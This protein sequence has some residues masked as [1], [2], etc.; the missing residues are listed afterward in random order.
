MDLVFGFFKNACHM[1]RANGE[2]HVNHKTTPPFDDWNIEKLAKQSFLTM[3]DC[4]DFNKEDYPGYDNKRGDSYRCDDPFPLGK[5]STFKFICNPRSMKK[6]LRGNHI[7]ISRQQTILPFHEEIQSIAQFPPPVDLNYLP[8]TSLLPKMN[9]FNCYPQT[10]HFPKLN[11]PIR[12]E[13]DLRNGY[14]TISREINNV[15]EIHGSVPCSADGYRY[16]QTNHFPKLNEPIRSEFDLRNGYNMI[17][18]E[19][20]NVTEI[21]G[22]V[23]CS[24]DGYRYARDMTQDTRR[25]VPPMESLQSLQPRPT[26][27][28]CRYSLTEP[29]RRT[30][31]MAPPMSLRARNGDHQYKAF[32]GSSSYMQ[33][34]LY[35]NAQ[36]PSY[37]QEEPYRN[38]PMPSHSFDIARYDLERYNAEVPR[39]VFNR[40]IYAMQ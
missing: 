24:A 29:L 18:R 7:E 6:H 2:I 4:I 23:A 12:S 14:N 15:T 10:N 19:I 16:P 34:E 26:P 5:C 36:R 35:R 37:F 22:N 17:S 8:R 30:M 3:I 27:T 11:E 39:R 20:S 13:F 32:E 21:H 28:I 31:D 33:E 38:V 9:Q 40:E 25:L 1:L